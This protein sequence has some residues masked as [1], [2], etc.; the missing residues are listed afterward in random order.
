MS[1]AI[2]MWEYRAR[3]DLKTH[4]EWALAT[5]Y[6]ALGSLSGS[7][8]PGLQVNL[9][10]PRLLI[11]RIQDRL[12]IKRARHCCGVS[13]SVIS[14]SISVKEFCFIVSTSYGHFSHNVQKS[15]LRQW[16]CTNK[17]FATNL[18]QAETDQ[19]RQW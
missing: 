15:D 5:T 7:A 17:I 4:C 10:I 11:G 14:Q 8:S 1:S 2:G 3:F 16:K 19:F 13:L 6:R 9:S 18:Q 12:F